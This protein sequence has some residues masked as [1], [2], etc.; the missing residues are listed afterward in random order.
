VAQQLCHQ[1]SRQRH[2]FGEIYAHVLYL[3]LVYLVAHDHIHELNI[4]LRHIRQYRRVCA[5]E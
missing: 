4:F 2:L 3:Q 1:T 5:W